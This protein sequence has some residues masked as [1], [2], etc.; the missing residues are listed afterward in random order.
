MSFHIVANT[1]N[2]V[3]G[4]VIPDYETL[5]THL[6][7]TIDEQIQIQDCSIYSFIADPDSDPFEE[8]GT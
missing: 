5:R 1:I 7:Q 3:L 4:S 8:E 6:W 2:S